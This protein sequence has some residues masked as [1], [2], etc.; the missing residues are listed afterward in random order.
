[1][2]LS[3][4]IRRLSRTVIT[5]GDHIDWYCC[6]PCIIFGG[7]IISGFALALI[8]GVFLS[9]P[10]RPS[11]WPVLPRCCDLGITKEDLD[12]G[13]KRRGGD[14]L[15]TLVIVDTTIISTRPVKAIEMSATKQ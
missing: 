11:L 14:R 4:S 2:N 5:S 12:A 15:D 3:R 8:I 1:M 6:S 9:V 13:R 10:I 7:K